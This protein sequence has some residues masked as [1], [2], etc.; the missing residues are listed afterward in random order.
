MILLNEAINYSN[1]SLE[2][3]EKMLESASTPK[4]KKWAQ[5]SIQYNKAVLERWEYVK[6]LIGNSTKDSFLN[7]K[8]ESYSKETRLDKEINSTYNN[9]QSFLTVNPDFN[10]RFNEILDEVKTKS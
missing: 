4:E 6:S 1:K 7:D 2:Y 10:Q 3:K 9:Y 8:M 5:L